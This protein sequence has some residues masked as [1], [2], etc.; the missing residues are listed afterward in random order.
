MGSLL[1]TL[2]YKPWSRVCLIPS[3]KEHCLS[4]ALSQIPRVKAPL[5]PKEPLETFQSMGW[6]WGEKAVSHNYQHPNMDS[7]RLA[8]T[9]EYLG[10]TQLASYPS[11][12]KMGR[13]KGK[14]HLGQHD[15]ASEPLSVWLMRCKTQRKRWPAQG[16]QSG[17][18]ET[19]GAG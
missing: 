3:G 14:T 2:E 13:G 17:V 10:I 12:S 11:S 15:L 7:S 4:W 8:Q 9:A 1:K 16:S 19:S 18:A 6:K 5:P